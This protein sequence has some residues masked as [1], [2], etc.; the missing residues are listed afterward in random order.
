MRLSGML[1]AAVI[2]APIGELGAATLRLKSGEARYE[3][4]IKTLGMGGSTIVGKNTGVIGQVQVIDTGKIQG[5]LVIPVV[6]FESNNTRRD[7]DIAK[8][9][10]YKEHPAITVEILEMQKSDIDSVLHAERGQVPM[11]ARV[12]AAGGSKIYDAI[13]KFQRT[14]PQEITCATEIDAKF[15][16]FGLKPPSFGLI[17][18]TAPDAIKL[19]GNMVFIVAEE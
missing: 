7:K 11:K 14:G 9:L 16:D 1:C 17:L 13:L 2:A 6:K 3:V 18:K 5:G 15:T 19:S 8:I 4:D 12:S 10:K